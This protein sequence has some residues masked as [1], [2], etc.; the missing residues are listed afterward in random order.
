MTENKF[1]GVSDSNNNNISRLERM[2]KAEWNEVEEIF[3]LFCEIT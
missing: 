1:S 2:K 3:H